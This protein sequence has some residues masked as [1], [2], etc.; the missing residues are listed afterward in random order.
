MMNQINTP[1]ISTVPRIGEKMP[2]GTVCVGVSPETHHPMYATQKDVPEKM[3]FKEAQE[4]AAQLDAHG[5]KDW[6][7]PTKAELNVM[8]NN[9]AAVGGFKVAGLDPLYY[10]TSTPD[11]GFGGCTQRFSDGI[12]SNDR[13]TKL[14]RVRCVR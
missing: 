6:R 3:E 7:V 14:L 2:D 5:H 12:Q 10:W 1:S 4:Y 11:Y 8:F 13:R 9:R